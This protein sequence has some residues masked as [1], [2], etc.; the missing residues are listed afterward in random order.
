MQS[1][2]KYPLRF[3]R[4]FCKP[5]YLD[6]IEGDLI[7]L[8]ELRSEKSTNKARR[9][10]YWDVLKSFRWV[11][12]KK[13]KIE[14]TTMNELTNYLKIY[15]R[16]FKRSTIQY[17]MNIFGLVLGFSILLFVL[18]YAT[19]ELKIDHYHSNVDRIYRVVEKSDTEEGIN[20]YVAVANPLANALKN[21]F[22]EIEET[23]QMVY[24]GSS[25]FTYKDNQIADREY[26]IVTKGIFNI[27]DFTV[28]GG[29]PVQDFQGD[30]GV[31]LTK[32][33]ARNLFG[34]EDPVGKVIDT[35]FDK[36]TVL[37][38][39]D[40]LPKTST[41]QQNIF[42]ITDFNKWSERFQEFFKSWDTHFMMTWVLFKEGAQPENVL[43]NK[44]AF[45]NKYIEPELIKEHDF[46]FQSI[47]DV[48]LG[49]EYIT[50]LGMEPLKAIPISS[51]KFVWII[52][53]IG[54]CVIIIASLNFINLSSVQT[55]KRSLEA[56]V[57]KVNGASSGQLRLQQFFETFVTIFMSYVLSLLLAMI[58]LPF[59][60][61]FTEKSVGINEFFGLNFILVQAGV[62]V[63]IWILAS[64]I[65]SIYYAGLD[66]SI[67][68]SKNVFSGKG[69][70]LRNGFVLL[71]YSIAIALI[72]GVIVLYQQM[73]FIQNKDLGFDQSG[74]ITLDIN[75][76]A[77]RR[78]FKGIVNGAVSH[79]SV[80]SV[81]A[82][83]R[84]P[85]E[86]KDL[87][88][89]DLLLTQ[90]SEPVNA[91]H[92][93]F[94]QYG[95]ETYGFDL[96]AGSNFSGIDNS[97]TL[98]VILNEKAVES[99]GLENPV[100]K[101]IWVQEDT[102]S[103]MQ[104]IGVVRDFHFQSLYESISPVVITCWNNSIRSIDYFAVR[105]TGDPK[106]VLS[107]L[108][109]VNAKFDPGTP[110]EFHFLDDQW[111]RYYK[112][113]QTRTN[114]IMISSILS[115]LIA[116][117]GL[118]GMI[119][120]T[121]ERRIK[122]IGIRKVVGASV[123]QIVRLILKDYF[124]L[125]VISMVIAAPIAWWYLNEWLGSFAYRIELSPLVFIAAFLLVLICSF[126]TVI[127][128]V[129]VTAKSNPVTALRYE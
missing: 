2:P 22:P 56:G 109:K 3:L 96:I 128:R 41:F 36:A 43:A 117:I 88:D 58:F 52:L 45:L 92:Y 26:A 65:P 103:H 129:Y 102:I 35:R 64:I 20:H 118:F 71:Q 77:A 84:V 27:W 72:I 74:I 12:F 8:F 38:V 95:I 42:F 48:H 80:Q 68:L 87:P 106:E 61:H 119:N 126:A 9:S 122:E 5:D 28:L 69:E 125:L 110:P 121:V 57:R 54:A 50:E 17:A 120:F 90:N 81:T 70:K 11:N 108:E 76:G 89:A 34:Q 19:S 127:S 116:V 53:A 59:F 85:G 25:V 97:D 13:L 113:D 4:W 10:F 39:I 7:E 37:A 75:S 1:P 79:P 32:T 30:V 111:A 63:L 82:T 33:F 49:S 94:D 21:D 78:N 112:A 14:H 104:V 60:N 66:R 62:F 40:D 55:L 31:V 91:S 24:F 23:A 18:I 73:S 6:E 83:S 124:I 93:G 101:M 67:L 47:K 123:P 46:D 98:K 15:F 115:I 107:H 105:Y 44:S 114:L 16:R 29:D 51:K 100:G 86:W 99:L